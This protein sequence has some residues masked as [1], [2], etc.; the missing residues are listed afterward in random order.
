MNYSKFVECNVAHALSNEDRL[1]IIQ[2]LLNEEMSVS[3]IQSRLYLEQSTVS[4]HLGILKNSGLLLAKQDGRKR[5]YRISEKYNDIL[6]KIVHLIQE[7]KD[8]CIF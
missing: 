8:L 6:D 1:S 5:K 4:H 2:M 7:K 3:D